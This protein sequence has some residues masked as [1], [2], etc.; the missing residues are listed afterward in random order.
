MSIG[1]S[2]GVSHST[3]RNYVEL[4]SST[5]M[6]RLLP[7]FLVNTGKRL[8][9]SPKIY[10]TDTGTSNALLG[11]SDFIQLSGHPA[12]GPTWESLIV[13]NLMATFPRANFYFYRTGHGAEI[14]LI[15]KFRDQIIA[16][17]CKISLSPKLAKGTYTAINDLKPNFTL[18][19][20]P[21]REG[22]PVKEDIEVANLIEAITKIRRVVEKV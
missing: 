20:A 21:V 10:L 6:V 1:N 14:D 11:L 3:V 7:P 8:I 19:I 5:F 4:L 16:I 13:S 17:E 18:I 2:L 15:L 22:W 12:I 9:K